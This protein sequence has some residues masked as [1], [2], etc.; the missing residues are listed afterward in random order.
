MTSGLAS[1]ILILTLLHKIKKLQKT[2]AAFQN[3][4]GKRFFKKG[5][6]NKNICVIIARRRG[7]HKIGARNHML[8]L[9]NISQE[10]MVIS[11]ED[12]S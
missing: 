12:N 10:H 11:Y 7:I 5:P 8:K 3:T 9:Q 1:E 2:S 4:I 6:I